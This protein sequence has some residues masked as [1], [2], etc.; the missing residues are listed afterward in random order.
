MSATVSGLVNGTSYTFTVHATNG[1]GTSPESSASSPVVPAG[2]PSP[3]TNASATS[4]DRAATLTWAASDPNGATVAGYTVIASP[5]GRTKTVAG[6]ATTA[7]V[8]SLTAGVTYTFTVVG[9]NNVGDSAPSAPSNAVTVMGPPGR[10]SNVTAS[11]VSGG[12]TVTWTAPSTNGSPV[13]TY[14]VTAF[15]GSVTATT[16]GGSTSASVSGLASGTAYNFTVVA[17][18]A[19]GDGA[20][21]WPSNTVTTPGSPPPPSGQPGAFMSVPAPASTDQVN[22][23]KAALQHGVTPGQYSDTELESLL[24]HGG[25]VAYLLTNGI[26]PDVRTF[27]DPCSARNDLSKIVPCPEV[28]RFGY[29]YGAIFSDWESTEV[30]PALFLAAGALEFWAATTYI[31]ETDPGLVESKAENMSDLARSYQSYA[32][33]MDANTVYV[34]NGYNFDGYVDGKIIDAKGPTYDKLLTPSSPGSSVYP[35][36]GVA[37]KLVQTANK[38]LAAANGVPIEWRVMEAGAVPKIQDVLARAGIT[39]INVVYYPMP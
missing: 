7:T 29:D 15:P 11:P 5:G 28:T 34:V 10:P 6:T 24:R 35:Y 27:Q 20:A 30:V 14:T 9:T 22:A 33:G 13:S 1:I 32:T 39:G 25:L 19:F 38:E 26:L 36:Q 37:D 8:T 2:R 16:G 12:A 17:T 3:P 23:F 4:G 21:S 18:N 31:E